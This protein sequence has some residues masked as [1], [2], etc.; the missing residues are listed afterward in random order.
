VRVEDEPGPWILS[1]RLA[2]PDNALNFL[3]AGGYPLPTLRIR[4]GR[5]RAL[6]NWEWPISAG[7][8]RSYSWQ[9]NCHSL[10]VGVQLATFPAAAERVQLAA[11]VTRGTL[12]EQGM[13]GT[14]QS[15]ASTAVL[16]GLIATSAVD[17]RIPPDTSHVIITETSTVTGIATGNAEVAQWSPTGLLLCEHDVAQPANGA[18]R[19]PIDPRARFLGITGAA[20]A[21]LRYPVTWVRHG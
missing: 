9:L 17:A 20:A 19:I 15:A 8:G 10:D 13:S 6:D 5:N 11:W 4:E 18:S 2:F 14:A 21:P 3:G 7:I 16:E 12:A 1:V